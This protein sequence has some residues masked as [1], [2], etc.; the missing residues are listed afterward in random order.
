MKNGF[1]QVKCGDIVLDEFRF[2]SAYNTPI[3]QAYT[4]ACCEIRRLTKEDAAA[5]VIGSRGLIGMDW[6]LTM[7]EGA[8][9]VSGKNRFVGTYSVEWVGDE[10]MYSPYTQLKSALKISD[11]LTGYMQIMREAFESGSDKVR[12]SN[13]SGEI[14]FN[15]RFPRW[16]ENGEWWSQE[17]QCLASDETL[18]TEQMAFAGL[19]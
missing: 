15:V 6:H 19:I 7:S 12:R 8:I 18:A 3:E 16:R 1:Y 5:N 10:D 4:R 17:N 11:T 14:I 13:R 2:L 9:I